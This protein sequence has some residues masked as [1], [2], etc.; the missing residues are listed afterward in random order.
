M[1]YF[2]K[3]L[4]AQPEWQEASD[5]GI[6]WSPLMEDW[7][8]RLVHSHI[9]PLRTKNKYEQYL[10]F[11][12][13]LNDI[14]AYNVSFPIVPK[15]TTRVRLVF[16]AHNVKEQIDKLVKCVCEWATEMLEIEAGTSENKL[17]SSARHVYAMQADLE[18]P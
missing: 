6:V 3:T 14:Q 7:E 18:R 9:V 8:S 13:V 16:H 4:E 12:L 5:E 17:P 1:K 15:G 11:H 2:F 10:F